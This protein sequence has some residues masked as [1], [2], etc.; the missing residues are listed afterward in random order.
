MISTIHLADLGKFYSYSESVFLVTGK[1]GLNDLH[2]SS[3]S[4][5]SQMPGTVITISLV[6]ILS[7]SIPGSRTTSH[8]S[9]E[10]I[11]QS[12]PVV[13]TYHFSVEL[14]SHL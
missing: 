3:S 8:T 7:L 6:I 4:Y 12:G 11:T 9:T 13:G 14:I 5:D 1:F 2:S 10:G